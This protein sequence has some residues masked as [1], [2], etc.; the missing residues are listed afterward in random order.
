MLPLLWVPQRP[1]LEQS[2]VLLSEVT[3]GQG[4]VAF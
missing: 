3:L 2:K 1:I 4:H